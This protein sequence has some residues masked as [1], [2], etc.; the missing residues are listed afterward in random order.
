MGRCW[1]RRCPGP[2]TGR[3]SWTCLRGGTIEVGEAARP[4]RMGGESR[5]FGQAEG[6]IRCEIGNRGKKWP[7]VHGKTRLH[8]LR[9]LQ[10]VSEEEEGRLPS[11][12]RHVRRGNPE[13][14]SLRG[15][16]AP[17][18]IPCGQSTQFGP[19]V[20]PL[21]RN[22]AMYPRSPDD[23]CP[24]PPRPVVRRPLLLRRRPRLEERRCRQRAA[25]SPLDRP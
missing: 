19:A 20:R 14:T 7:C 13:R 17:R 11:H 24:N 4:A 8:R 21:E 16:L 9:P 18:P 22:G 2:G 3:M 15:R 25:V 5:H 1:C 10:S 12:V 6:Q 23:W